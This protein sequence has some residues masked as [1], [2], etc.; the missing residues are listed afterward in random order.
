MKSILYKS[1]GAVIIFVFGIQVGIITE[2]KLAGHKLPKIKLELYKHI[3]TPSL[4]KVYEKSKE[5]RII[6]DTIKE[7]IWR[8]STYDVNSKEI[9]SMV[10][11]EKLE[12]ESDYWS[13]NK[14][15]ETNENP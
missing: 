3:N 5:N 2:Q 4:E 13:T 6:L 14:L 11:N 7:G 1:L 15:I 10:F 12:N 8:I 9:R